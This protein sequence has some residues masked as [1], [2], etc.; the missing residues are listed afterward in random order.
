MITKGVQ[1][2]NE[3]RE[4]RIFLRVTEEERKKITAKAKALGLRVG[5]YIRFMA[6]KN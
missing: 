6:L 2:A 1:M 3:K 4:R 5:T